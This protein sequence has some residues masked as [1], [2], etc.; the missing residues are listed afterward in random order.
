MREARFLMPKTTERLERL[1]EKEAQLKVRIQQEKARLSA[2]ARKERTGKLI[3]WGVA[4]EQLL[5]DETF[6]ADW[7]K[8]Q[9]QRVLTGKTLERAIPNQSNKLPPTV[10][11]PILQQEDSGNFL[12]V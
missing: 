11:E 8:L 10:N 9:C 3:A 2:S 6:Q 12:S 5:A 1:K 4:V 7:W